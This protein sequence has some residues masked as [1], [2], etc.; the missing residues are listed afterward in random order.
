V[1]A[2]VS[3]QLE[4]IK[5][6]N[7]LLENINKGLNAYLEKKRLFFP[8]YVI[9]TLSVVLYLLYQQ[10]DYPH[11]RLSPHPDAPNPGVMSCHSLTR[12]QEDPLV[13]C[14]RI[15]SCRNLTRHAG[16]GGRR[17]HALPNS[18][19]GFFCTAARDR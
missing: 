3:G 10:S 16:R 11:R 7:G 4:K 15:I 5:D 17:T 6:S 18:Q 9:Y 1:A 2:S 14:L 13:P 8:R 12:T 19:P